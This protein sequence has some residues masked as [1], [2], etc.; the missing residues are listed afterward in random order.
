MQLKVPTAENTAAST[1]DYQT[2]HVHTRSQK[3]LL[4]SQRGASF[5]GAQK[6]GLPPTP[7]KKK[8]QPAINTN[9]QY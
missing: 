3:D 2:A 6:L 1:N 9:N 8:R 7:F 4:Q 5:R